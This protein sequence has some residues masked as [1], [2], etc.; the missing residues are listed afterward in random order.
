MKVL[1]NE[2]LKELLQEKIAKMQI[3]VDKTIL[4]GTITEVEYGKISTLIYTLQDFLA[5]KE[6]I[7]LME[8]FHKILQMRYKEG[9]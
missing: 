1:T 8:K 6:Q 7:E 5:D 9:V 2:R 4:K 3:R